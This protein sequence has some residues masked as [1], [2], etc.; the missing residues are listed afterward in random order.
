[1]TAVLDERGPLAAGDTLTWGRLRDLRC[2]ELE[3]AAD[4]WARASHRADAARDR[5]DK[6]VLVGI[7]ESQESEAA[8]AA[9]RRLR[10]LSRDFAYV[11]VESGLVRTA[12]RGL[13][14][15]LKGAQRALRDA[16]DAA[17]TLR[18]TVHP[19]GSVS[20]PP[21][22]S[23]GETLMGG[24]DGS[25]LMAGGRAA[26]S[27]LLQS[28]TTAHGLRAPNPGAARAQ[29]IADEIVRAVGEARAA[30]A[31][32][33]AELKGLMAGRAAGDADGVVVSGA[34]WRDAVADLRQAVPADA[35]PA[36]Y[37]T[38][39]DGLSPELRDA[40]V[41]SC[42]ELVGNLDGIPA[43]VRDRAN[44]TNLTALIGELRHHDDETSRTR[45]AGLLRIKEQ[46][47]AG[48]HPRPFLLGI[49]NEGNGRAIVSFGN[50]D[51]ARNV[52]AYVP[53]LGT[54]LDADFANGDL[55]RARDVALGVSKLT[56]ASV[57]SVAW[58]GYDAPQG[59][60]VMGTGAAEAGGVAYNRFMSGL[61]ATNEH[62]DP[63]LT[64]IGH[65]YGSRT[66][67]AAAQHPGGIPGADDIVLVGSPGVGVDRA[68]DLGVGKDHVFVGAAKND[69]V[70]K[71]PSPR[72][73]EAGSAG[74]LVG[75]EKGARIAGALADRRDD[76]LWFGRDPA[77]R[78][79][80]ARRFVV[81][82]GPP[83]FSNGVVPAHSAYFDRGN[84]VS[85]GD[86]IALI[87]A[88]KPDQ[89]KIAEPR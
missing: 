80:G 34:M 73:V 28:A 3:D 49:G 23:S 12:L 84:G 58:L 18:F 43:A 22:P 69:F 56:G 26:G 78:A 41:A 51:T 76:E 32:Y 67:G 54:S 77:S 36:A 61:V 83:A 82:D 4:G 50:P 40:Y 60:G 62:E 8:R 44:R 65:S 27:G 42:P 5:L 85:S 21:A 46:L 11:C 35:E 38:W 81:P 55:K 15:D 29:E 9:V 1:M 72:E 16:L 87:V 31:R 48:G 2:G 17:E 59:A 57:A 20:Y 63:H 75:G 37:K 68:E 79:F 89:L 71:L 13:A 74:F 24:D 66:V 6:H 53:G 47:D 19:D 10:T 64:A 88:G 39:W 14:T 7:T 52:S 86:S 25:E 33:T 30:D 45:L 70:T